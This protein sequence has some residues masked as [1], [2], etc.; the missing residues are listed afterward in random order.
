MSGL[1]LAR[2]R[3]ATGRLVPA[4]WRRWAPLPVVLTGT[5]VIVLDFFIVNAVAGLTWLLPKQSWGSRPSNLDA[6]DPGAPRLRRTLRFG[7]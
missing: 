7:R 6:R 1:D 2:A 5:F 3:P 4:R